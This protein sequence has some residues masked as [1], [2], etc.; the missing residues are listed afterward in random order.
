MPPHDVAN[1]FWWR[2]KDAIRNSAF[3]YGQANFGHKKLDGLSSRRVVQKLLD[4]KGLDW[5][6]EPTWKKW[7]LGIEYQERL[8]WSEW[9]NNKEYQQVVR[10][11]WTPV[12]ISK[13]V[14]DRT[15][16]D[17]MLDVPSVPAE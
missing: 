8:E 3:A 13:L 15:L 10:H 6:A 9:D 1:Y 7:G 11:Q 16:F 2:Q 17:G 12:E 14:D 5:H 4:E